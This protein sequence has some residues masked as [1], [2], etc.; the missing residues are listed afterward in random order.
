MN[1][2]WKIIN[3]TQESAEI[4][5]YE[6]IGRDFWSDEG[7]A[8]KDFAA[9][10]R[11]LGDV[12]NISLRI[13]SPGGSVFEGMAIYNLLKSHP[14][15]VDVYVDGIAA[16]IASVIAMAGDRI[17]MPE[18]TM[19]MI[20]DPAGVVMGTSVDMRKMAEALDK[21]KESIKSS[22]KRTAL[23]DKEIDN[24]MTDETWL[25]AKDCQEKGFCD[26]VIEA[27]KVAAHFDLKAM[28]YKSLPQNAAAIINISGKT[29]EE[30][31][32]TKDELKKQFPDV[33]NAIHQEGIDAAKAE[34]EAIKATVSS[35]SAK[36]ERERILSV[37]DQAI[38][39]HEDLINALMFDGVTSGE[40]A[41]VKVLQAEKAIRNSSLEKLKADSVKAPVTDGSGT[42]AANTMKR[43]EFN[44]LTPAA[45]SAFIKNGGKVTD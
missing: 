26:E 38:S 23:T 31:I 15:N 24:L 14:A 42:G 25:T 34:V 13:N 11:N 10:L 44:A 1:K 9:D 36:A 4:L 29:K 8:A 7:I 37:K 30:K 28:G 18:N 2:F 3:K 35:E 6:Q 40:Q 22:Y 21:I 19:M 16:S 17:I 5:M 45:R 20:H 39:G 33:Y 43:K 32:M 41:A 12:K 27:V